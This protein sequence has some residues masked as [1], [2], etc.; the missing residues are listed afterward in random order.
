[1]TR[2]RNAGIPFYA[3]GV[4]RE[5]SVAVTVLLTPHRHREPGE[6]VTARSTL[7]DEAHRVSG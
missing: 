2:R 4:F 5:G 6:P 7:T 1:M 3:L